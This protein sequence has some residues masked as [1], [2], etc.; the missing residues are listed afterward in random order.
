MARSQ[1]SSSLA[2][3]PLGVLTIVLGATPLG[4]LPVPGTAQ[5]LTI[6]HIPVVLGGVLCG[7]LIGMMLGLLF[8]LGNCWQVAP[9]D[10]LVQVLPR[11]LS[12]LVAGLTFWAA[13]RF[14]NP[15]SQITVGSLCAALAGSFTNTLGVILGGVLKG[16]MPTS[17]VLPVILFHGCPEAFVAVL[18][19]L[20]FAVVR[21]SSGR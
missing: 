20:P 8:G 14:G 9:H 19:T 11:A 7:P 17:E 5:F 21:G 12:G 13:R 6:A 2:W 15:H 16:L 1:E 3:L 18:I 4:Y 10:P